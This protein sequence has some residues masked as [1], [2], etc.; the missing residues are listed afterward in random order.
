MGQKTSDH[1]RDRHFASELSDRRL[2]HA[3]VAYPHM[4]SGFGA[5]YIL[6]VP[7]SLPSPPAASSQS[8]MP[9]LT[10]DE[11]PRITFNNQET[12]MM[13][14]LLKL[15]QDF[16]VDKES[17][18]GA[19]HSLSGI[20]QVAIDK[21]VEMHGEGV[22]ENIPD[23]YRVSPVSSSQVVLPVTMHFSDCLTSS[24][25]TDTKTSIR[26]QSKRSRARTLRQGCA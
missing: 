23:L 7:P 9:E 2:R 17:P 3:S 10:E 16:L 11:P 4:G 25:T 24:T 26:K 21:L 18:E 12:A 5:I 19:N 8:A 6:V 13:K 15:F 1:P 22:K 20:A 14:G